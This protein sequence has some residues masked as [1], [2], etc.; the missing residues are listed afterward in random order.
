[1]NQPV[2]TNDETLRG[3]FLC[4]G[5]R[6]RREAGLDCHAACFPAVGVLC[7]DFSFRP[8]PLGDGWFF[9]IDRRGDSSYPLRPLGYMDVKM[10][11]PECAPK[12]LE[13]RAA[14]GDLKARAQL[15]HRQE[16]Q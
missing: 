10:W 3:P 15:K 7:E 8:L 6:R 11:C 13:Q 12:E 9:E 5:T 2:S 1:V 4:Q 14:G 16:T